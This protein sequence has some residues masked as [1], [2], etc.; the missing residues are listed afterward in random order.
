[1]RTS[2]S[3][4]FHYARSYHIENERIKNSNIVFRSVRQRCSKKRNDK[5]IHACTFYA[6]DSDGITKSRKR[7]KRIMYN[8]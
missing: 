3:L 1:M 2:L 8:G 5:K 4:F 7:K 6:S